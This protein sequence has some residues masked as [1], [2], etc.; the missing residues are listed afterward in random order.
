MTNTTTNT[1]SIDELSVR[2]DRLERSM[3]RWRFG[4]V[5]VVVMVSAGVLLGQAKDEGKKKL[6]VDELVVTDKIELKGQLNDKHVV[7]RIFPGL[8][9]SNTI[10]CSNLRAT[11]IISQDIL[12]SNGDVFL[13]LDATDKKGPGLYFKDKFQQNVVALKLEHKDKYKSSVLMLSN[14]KS[15]SSVLLAAEDNA[16]IIGCIDSKGVPTKWIGGKE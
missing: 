16:A 10:S 9:T 13:S 1:V 4:F 7:T 6:V 12:V 11:D 8:I 5:V 14:T 15:K 3:K 2:F